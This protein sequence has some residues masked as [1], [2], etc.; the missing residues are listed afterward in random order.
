MQRLTI[1]LAALAAALAACGGGDPEDE[2]TAFATAHP[3][4]EAHQVSL[5]CTAD[6]DGRAQRPA[7]PPCD[8]QPGQ[9]Q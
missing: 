6:D 2:C 3:T 4:R 9:C 7:P 5:R 1:C 8:T